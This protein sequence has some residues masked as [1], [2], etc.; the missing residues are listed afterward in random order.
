MADEYAEMTE[1]ELEIELEDRG[2][3]ADGL[4]GN[5]MRNA[6]RQHDREMA[7]A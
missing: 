7:E 2:I 6:L 5:E 4:N 1:E 3:E